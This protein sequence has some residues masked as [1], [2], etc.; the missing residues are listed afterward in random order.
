M[1]WCT[2]IAVLG[3]TCWESWSPGAAHTGHCIGWAL[4]D[5]GRVCL[6]VSCVVVCYL[7]ECRLSS[8]VLSEGMAG[9]FAACTESGKVPLGQLISNLSTIVAVS[10]N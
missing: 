7:V 8:M 2:N 5:S 4:H 10:R 6:G 3:E 9:S 1:P